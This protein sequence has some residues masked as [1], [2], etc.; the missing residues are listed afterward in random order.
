ME[1]GIK[2]TKAL[3]EKA[4]S[5]AVKDAKNKAKIMLAPLDAKVGDVQ[6]I[7]ESG[8]ARPMPV[9]RSLSMMAAPAMTGASAVPDPD[10]YSESDIEVSSSV[11]VV[12]EIL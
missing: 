10:S 5:A 2:D 12:F 4:L 7:A 3:E 1:Y 11:D 6:T 9:T 8:H